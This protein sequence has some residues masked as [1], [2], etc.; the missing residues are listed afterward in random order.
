MPVRS[1]PPAVLGVVVALSLAACGGNSAS[2]TP[3]TTPSTSVT[4][5][6]VAGRFDYSQGAP[7]GLT[8]YG[9]VREDGGIEVHDVIYDS[10]KGGVVPAYVVVPRSGVGPTGLR[11]GLVYVPWGYGDRSEFL[12]ESIRMGRLGAVSILI[13]APQKRPDF[14][15]STCDTYVQAVVD[16][17]RA[18]DVLSARADVDAARIGYVGH[19]FGAVWGGVLAGVDKRFRCFVLMAGLP[20][21]IQ[22]QRCVTGCDDSTLNAV[23]FIGRAAPSE[24]FFQ[25]ANTDEWVSR[26][27][28]DA[29]FNAASEPKTATWYNTTHELKSAEADADRLRFICQRL[30]LPQT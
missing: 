10:P 29:Y 8:D 25:F 24:L 9:I 23:N 20:R 1:L 2:P 19:S 22:C 4:S 7:I 3:S 13:D 17:R 14:T 16:M 11:A 5:D 6:P 27:D 18:F 30:G 12:G 21:V 28:A 26:D 15:R